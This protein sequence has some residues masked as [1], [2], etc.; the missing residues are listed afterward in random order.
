MAVKKIILVGEDLCIRREGIA[1]G[2]IT[3][4]HLVDAVPDGAVTAQTAANAEAQRTFAYER[5][6]TG[7]DIDTAYISGDTVPY[8]HAPAGAVVY[9]LGVAAGITA[10]DLVESAA[11]G[12]VQTLTSGRAIGRALE[13]TAAAGR[14]KI[15]IL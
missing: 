7:D 11:A 10:G 13:T 2:A 8:F 3:P 4:G 1:G 9:A 12:E 5:E 14:I 15:E 6:F